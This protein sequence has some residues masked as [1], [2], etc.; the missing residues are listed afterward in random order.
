V[1]I[2]EMRVYIL[3]DGIYSYYVTYN[4]AMMNLKE[5]TTFK[6]SSSGTSGTSTLSKEVPEVVP[7]F[8]SSEER[9]NIPEVVLVVPSSEGAGI[10]QK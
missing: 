5:G 7:V 2:G 3:W 4:I 8:P 6:R 1:L 10:F 9:G